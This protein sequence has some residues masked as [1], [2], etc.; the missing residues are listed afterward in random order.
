MGL[1]ELQRVLLNVKKIDLF[2]EENEL[3]LICKDSNESIIYLD[4]FDPYDEH[5]AI[6]MANYIAQ[7]CGLNTFMYPDEEE[8]PVYVAS[9]GI[10]YK[11]NIFQKIKRLF[12]K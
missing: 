5:I 7:M 1:E 8:P 2:E 12:K 9:E 4:C 11:E 10:E 3:V 6:N